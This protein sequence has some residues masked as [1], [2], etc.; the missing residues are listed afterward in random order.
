MSNTTA[1]QQPL[2]NRSLNYSVSHRGATDHD[3]VTGLKIQNEFPPETCYNPRI[4][5]SS[6]PTKTINYT[7][8]HRRSGGRNAPF[9]S[10]I[11]LCF[12]RMLGAGKLHHQHGYRCFLLP[13]FH[14]VLTFILHLF[15]FL[16]Y[17]KF[18]NSCSD[19]YTASSRAKEDESFPSSSRGVR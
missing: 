11:T 3:G 4:Q 8:N 2:G 15:D 18:P 12:D 17:R 9:K 7:P 16:L 5:A 19:R 14:A 6:I 10:P 1:R 13:K